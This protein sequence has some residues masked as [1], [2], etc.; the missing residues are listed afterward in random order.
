MDAQQQ[1]WGQPLDATAGQPGEQPEDEQQEGAVQEQAPELAEDQLLAALLPM[2]PPGQRRGA[3]V[4]LLAAALEADGVLPRLLQAQQQCQ[5]D[6]EGVHRLY[7]RLAGVPPAAE[8]ADD[9]NASAA[10]SSGGS[11]DASGHAAALR[12]MMALPLEEARAVLRSYVV[13][14]TAKDCAIMVTLRRLQDAPPLPAD[15]PAAAAA[16]LGGSSLDAQQ[17]QRQQQAE[18]QQPGC[19]TVPAC[20]GACFRYRL[21]FVD[22]DLKP[23]AKIPQHW[24]LDRRILA[25]AQRHLAS[26]QQQQQMQQQ[27][28]LV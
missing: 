13:A 28:I 25:A 24:Q 6:V 8:A 4:E 17:Q 27:L 21:C 9:A 14:A 11:E 10:S 19:I 12:Q 15:G 20:E 2:L 18:L 1:S 3:L 16:A 26:G 7:C 5:Y 23:L 22:L